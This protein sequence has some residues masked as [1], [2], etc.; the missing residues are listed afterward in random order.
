MIS[1]W[2]TGQK[3]PEALPVVMMNIG[4]HFKGLGSSVQE[5]SI[6]FLLLSSNTW[7]ALA[8][9]I[10]DLFYSKSSLC[11]SVVCQ[12]NTDLYQHSHLAWRLATGILEKDCLGPNGPYEMRSLKYLKSLLN[13]FINPK[14]EFSYSYLF[15]S[16]ANNTHLCCCIYITNWKEADVRQA[17][18]TFK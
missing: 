4:L 18:K 1:C 13:M 3:W 5:V 15:S 8:V 10:N 11:R 6:L 16:Y 12:A 2:K 9:V 7:K 17:E 14:H